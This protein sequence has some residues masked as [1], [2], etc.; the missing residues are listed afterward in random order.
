MK[1]LLT[2]AS[3]FIG[4]HMAAHL[5]GAGHHVT[6]TYRTASPRTDAL[7]GT[8]G[9]ELVKVDLS[10]E[11]DLAPLPSA[12]DVIVHVAASSTTAIEGADELIAVNVL[13]TRNI[14]RHALDVG[15]KRLVYMS[16]LSVHGEI[17]VSIVDE[18]TPVIAPDLYGATKHLGERIIAQVADRLPSVAVRLP[19]VLGAGAH[20]A[21]LPS[22]ASRA[23]SGAPV[24]VYNPE[25][26]FNNAVH[27]LDLARFVTG[28]LETRWNGFHAF[29]VG[30]GD[31]MEIRE[32]VQFLLREIG[33]EVPIEVADAAQS[34]FTIS[35]SYACR[36]FGYEPRSMREILRRYAQD[37]VT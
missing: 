4:S 20:R 19:G 31:A 34:G 24:T 36:E 7:G 6:G 12:V 13:G 2:G 26:A 27:V 15:A 35:S 17:R 29:P 25:S 37:L 5:A 16:S 14:V 9:L 32:L 22:V 11:A 8:A 33:C 28:V 23:R 18:R 30:A 3:S 10:S 21:W 1:I